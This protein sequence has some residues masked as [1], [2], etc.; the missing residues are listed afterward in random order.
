[1]GDFNK[2]HFNIEGRVIA[3]KNSRQIGYRNG[4]MVNFPSKRYNEF[5]EMALWQ[6]K[7]IKGEIKPPYDVRYCFFIKGKMDADLDNLIASINDIL[8]EAG[9]IENDRLIYQME[10]QK[11][12]GQDDFK[13]TIEIYELT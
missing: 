5:K 11:I 3:K 12:M 10:A 1:M 7:T 9:I 13:T 4:R 6:L 8:Q 2:I